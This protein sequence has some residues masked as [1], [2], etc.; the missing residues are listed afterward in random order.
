MTKC[1]RVLIDLHFLNGE[2]VAD[3]IPGQALQ[4]LPL[5]RLNSPAPVHIEPGVLPTTELLAGHRG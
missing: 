3:N 1:C 2:R 5:I 4:I